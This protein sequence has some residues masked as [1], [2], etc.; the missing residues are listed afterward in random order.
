MDLGLRIQIKN[1]ETQRRRRS[2]RL[3]G[4]SK[5][6]S[7]ENLRGIPTDVNPDIQLRKIRKRWTDFYEANP[8]GPNMTKQKLLDYAKEID[9]EFGHLFLPPVR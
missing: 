3:A 6:N 2:L 9:D 7:L 5:M 1:L 4:E 8:D